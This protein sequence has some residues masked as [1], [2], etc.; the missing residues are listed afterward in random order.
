MGRGVPTIYKSRSRRAPRLTPPGCRE[1]ACAGQ[2]V[3]FPVG[4]GRQWQ[5]AM[6]ST[7]RKRTCILVSMSIPCQIFRKS[8][9]VIPSYT[10]SGSICPTQTLAAS[11]MAPSAMERAD[12]FSMWGFPESSSSTT[13]HFDI[14]PG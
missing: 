2:R 1:A 12:S 4:R 10:W 11:I 5:R 3:H 8:S 9:K 14:L 13:L 7:L 6:A